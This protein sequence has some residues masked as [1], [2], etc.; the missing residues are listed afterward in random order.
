MG[1]RLSNYVTHL[2]HTAACWI[3]MLGKLTSLCPHIRIKIL[4]I[5]IIP[6]HHHIYF[7]TFC[8]SE[9]MHTVL[10]TLEKVC[11]RK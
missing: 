2:M 5:R 7:T 1:L 4:F 9:S 11:R 10:F 8:H 3:Y 6:I